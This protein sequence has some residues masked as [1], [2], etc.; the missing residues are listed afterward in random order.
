MVLA[1]VLGVDASVQ[2]LVE[3]VRREDPSPRHVNDHDPLDA[4]LDALQYNDHHTSMRRL[5]ELP[6]W[7]SMETVDAAVD[8][9]TGYAE[10]LAPVVFGPS[11][12]E[13][14][15]EVNMP[16]QEAL[17][18]LRQVVRFIAYDSLL[19]YLYPPNHMG[20]SPMG[21]GS[22]IQLHYSN[23]ACFPMSTHRHTLTHSTFSP[24][25]RPRFRCWQSPGCPPT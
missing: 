4:M 11:T 7:M 6:Q 20:G 19:C 9:A 5:L 25:Y 13:I 3:A 14:P 12:G 2:A 16:G 15:G 1:D 23:R 10:R 18:P 21:D 24:I 22:P 17:D 8:T